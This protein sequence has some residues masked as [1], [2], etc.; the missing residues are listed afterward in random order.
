MEPK[1]SSPYSQ[2]PAIFFNYHIDALCNKHKD[3]A[4]EFT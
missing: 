2:V 1:G 3:K 4:T